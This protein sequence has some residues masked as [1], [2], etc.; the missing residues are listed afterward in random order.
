[1]KRTYFFVIIAIALL[2][3][4]TTSV[5]ADA[6]LDEIA[7]VSAGLRTFRCHVVVEQ[8]SGRRTSTVELSFEFKR[9]PERMRIEYFAPRNMKG[10]IVALDGTYFYNYLPSMNRTQKQPL[11]SAS[12][13]NPGKDMG[14]LFD[15]V[16]GTF[17]ELIAHSTAQSQGS[18]TIRL[19]EG[20]DAV[21]VRTDCYQLAGPDARQQVWFDS[22]TDAPVSIEVYDGNKLVRSISVTEIALNEPIDDAEFSLE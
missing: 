4:A 22:D 21:S 3:F 5:A 8:S 13:D 10:S 1:M 20:R 2:V 18:E 7:S 12:G 9:N 11:S 6:R 17:D 19:G 14:A 15:F 16:A